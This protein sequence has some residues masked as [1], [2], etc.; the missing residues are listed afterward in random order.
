MSISISGGKKATSAK[1]PVTVTLGATARVGGRNY[2]NAIGIEFTGTECHVV[3]I[4]NRTKVVDGRAS[5][6][7]FGKDAGGRNTLKF[8]DPNSPD[9]EVDSTS[10]AV[11]YYDFSYAGEMIGTK[12]IMVDAPTLTGA[13]YNLPGAGDITSFDAYSFCL[14][15]KDIIAIIKWDVVK[16]SDDSQTPTASL[17]QA[18]AWW[19]TLYLGRR[20]LTKE[21]YN[22]DLYL[23]TMCMK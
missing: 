2:P 12:F 17:L 16:H 23:P 20:V 5:T 19:T 1:D 14:S 10:A 21:G 11:P 13:K 8:S 9:W 3:Q 22:A 15:D 7:S 18:D 4:F 6:Q